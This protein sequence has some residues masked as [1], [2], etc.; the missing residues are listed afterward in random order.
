VT[1]I[2]PAPARLAKVMSP[3]WLT[4][5]LD[6]IDEGQRV[7][8][9]RVVNEFTTVASKIRFEAVIEDSDEHQEIRSYCVKGDFREEPVLDFAVEARFYREFGPALGVRMPKCVYAGPDEQGGHSLFIMDD[10]ASERVTF[11][12]SQVVYSP[13]MSAAALGQ[14]ALLHARTW[15]EANLV[16]LD[17]LAAN[18]PTLADIVPVEVLQDRIND[19][20]AAA[21]PEYLRDAERITMAMRRVTAPQAVCVVH[22]DPHSLNIYLDREGRP[23]LLDWQTV[24]VGHWATDV[25]YHIGAVLDVD[26]RRRNEKAL[27][28]GYLDELAR[29]GQEPPA[30][31]DAWDSY[32]SHFAYGYFM[33]SLAQTTPRVDIVEHIPRLG[34][35]IHD[36]DTF[37]RLGV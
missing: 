9:T 12:D 20:R 19:G 32:A 15:G 27:L 21:L 14:L 22:G 18:R 4:R 25:S 17:W 23:S 28:R 29:L 37:A 11:L 26:S 24:H 1:A 31:D 3:E 10:L 33:W 2:D 8:S 35:A 5:A 34:T 36:H 6:G 30:W 7:V 13:E 16:G